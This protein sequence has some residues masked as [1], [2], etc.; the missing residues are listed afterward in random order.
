MLARRR[1][2][3]YLPLMRWLLALALLAVVLPGPPA[4]AAAPPGYCPHLFVPD[5]YELTCRADGDD[6]RLT[7]R[8][9]DELLGP[10]SVLTLRPVEQDVED[11]DIWLRERLTLNLSEFALAFKDLLGRPE[12]PLH[13][14]P[15]SESLD[16]LARRLR[17]VD[18]L[19]LQ[20][21]G[22]PVQREGDEAWQIECDWTLG[23]LELNGLLRLVYRGDQPYAI[24]VWAVDPRRMR[25]LTAIAN[26]F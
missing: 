15:L 10:F 13:A 1:P 4:E 16:K 7:V 17:L 14:A 6:W 5:G 11:P 12:S 9:K 21:C 3:Y 25:H 2:R 22:F 8:P 19:P 18:Q 26:S 20:S 24:S 23:P